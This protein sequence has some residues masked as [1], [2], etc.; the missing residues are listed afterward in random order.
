MANLFFDYTPDE[1]K[2]TLNYAFEWLKR[3]ANSENLFQQFKSSNIVPKEFLSLRTYTSKGHIYYK[4]SKTINTQSFE[5]SANS[6]GK[7]IEEALKKFLINYTIKYDSYFSNIIE[8]IQPS[9]TLFQAC[10]KI[11]NQKLAQRNHIAASERI[12]LDRLSILQRPEL[13]KYMKKKI[14]TLTQADFQQL[15]HL[16]SQLKTLSIGNDLNAETK[17]Q[18][19]SMISQAY[20]QYAPRFGANTE[21]LLSIKPPTAI[22]L[23]SGISPQR[24][25]LSNVQMV[26]LEAVAKVHLPFGKK[27]YYF[28][29]GTYITALLYSGLRKGEFAGLSR[30]NITITKFQTNWTSAVLNIEQQIKPSDE[31]MKSDDNN[32]VYTKSQKP[33]RD[34]TLLLTD[35]LKTEQSK[36]SIPCEANVTNI[37]QEICENKETSHSNFQNYF[38]FSGQEKR[39]AS[40]PLRLEWSEKN[41]PLSFGKE[42]ARQQF[43]NPARLSGT[44][45]SIMRNCSLHPAFIAHNSLDEDIGAKRPYVF[46]IHDLRHT[47]ISWQI[48][49][50]TPIEKIA[51]L[52]GHSSLNTTYSYYRQEKDELER[53]QREDSLIQS[54]FIYFF[55]RHELIAC[56]NP[57]ITLRE[58]AEIKR[59]FNL[60]DDDMR[61]LPLCTKTKHSHKYIAKHKCSYSEICSFMPLP[62]S[63]KSYIYGHLP[64]GDN[65]YIY[66]VAEIPVLLE[67]IYQSAVSAKHTKTEVLN[68]L[69]RLPVGIQLDEKPCGLSAKELKK[70]CL[71][72]ADF[73]LFNNEEY[74]NHFLQFVSLLEIFEEL[75][76]HSY[77]PT[78]QIDNGILLYDGSIID[79]SSYLN[80]HHIYDDA[81]QETIINSLIDVSSWIA[82]F[83]YDSL[84]FV[85]DN[86]PL[87]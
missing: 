4:A 37:L 73:I 65:F 51:R 72:Y 82:D 69:H 84:S 44:L 34:N 29:N 39:I 20:S 86:P 47:Y 27:S 66:G 31:I 62:S 35:T 21:L 48:R 49:K 3:N 12:I 24:S 8:P 6:N 18:L 14:S 38:V 81:F 78:H 2:A 32:I 55:I 76:A 7:T 5:F 79:L 45:D 57:G 59:G 11:T 74:S 75:D 16:I 10:Q 53:L 61:F 85:V 19:W 36:R 63:S 80:I 54:D 41:H 58:Y 70:L 40:K 17:K 15:S 26:I 28:P 71:Q 60:L 67:S 1:L 83:L 23:S 50:G 56:Y 25:V 13:Q 68:L 77:K 9:D 87:I 42:L 33:K 46:S 52:V 22:K 64:D 43:Y 30:N